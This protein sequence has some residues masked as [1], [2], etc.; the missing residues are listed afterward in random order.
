MLP[1]QSRFKDEDVDGHLD[2]I[3]SEV[4]K[5]EPMRLLVPKTICIVNIFQ[6]SWVG[7]LKNDLPSNRFYP[8]ATDVDSHV[9]PGFGV[10]PRTSS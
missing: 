7:F 1:Y 6:L 4:V 8:E 9:P 3:C 2:D 5:Q 10:H